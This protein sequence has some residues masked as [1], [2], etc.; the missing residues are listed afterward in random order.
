MQLNLGSWYHK[1]VGEP[2]QIV[3]R[4]YLTFVTCLFAAGA[5]IEE[6][7]LAAAKQIDLL[8]DLEADITRSAPL[9]D[10]TAL[11]LSD[12]FIIGKKRLVLVE[13]ISPSWS[14]IENVTLS[15]SHSGTVRQ[16]QQS[17][18]W[19]ITP[20]FLFFHHFFCRYMQWRE[21]FRFKNVVFMRDDEMSEVVEI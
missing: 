18:I 1:Y 13:E 9:A 19:F 16:L 6:L 21:R 14:V 8:D 15:R 3:Y 12:P 2:G 20:C 5:E 17:S 4:F 7:A 10:S 11:K